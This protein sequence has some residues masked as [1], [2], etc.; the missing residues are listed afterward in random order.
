MKAVILSKL[1]NGVEISD[2]SNG[3][4]RRFSFYNS[5]INLIVIKN[6][7]RSDWATCSSPNF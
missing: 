1:G 3:I 4:T 6:S 5:N 2:V 7:N